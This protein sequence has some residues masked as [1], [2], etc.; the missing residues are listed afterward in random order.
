MSLAAQLAALLFAL[1]GV[2]AVAVLAVALARL[3]ERTCP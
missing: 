3:L 1:A 2:A